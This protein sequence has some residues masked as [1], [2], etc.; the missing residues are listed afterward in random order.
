M[1]NYY[2]YDPRKLIINMGTILYCNNTI[3]TKYLVARVGVFQYLDTTIIEGN[4]IY[5]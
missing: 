4:E 2:S 1:K 5:Q 3:L